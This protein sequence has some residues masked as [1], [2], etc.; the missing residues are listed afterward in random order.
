MAATVFG[1]PRYGVINDVTVTGLAVGNYSTTLTT[2]QSYA[3]NHL[4][5]DVAMSIYNDG[6]E[7]TLSGVVAVLATGI[8]PLLAAA[9]TLA[10]GTQHAKFATTPV[11]GAGF[12]VTGASL[13]RA[14]TE[15]ETGEISGVHKPLF[16]VASSTVLTD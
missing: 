16:T 8:V 1:T 10:N 4:G 13:S 11:T 6:A 12:V 2:E 7:V 14:N 9:V 5:N 15:F 3:K